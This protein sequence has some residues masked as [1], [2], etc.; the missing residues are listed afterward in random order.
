MADRNAESTTP[1]GDSPVAQPAAQPLGGRFGFGRNTLKNR[2]AVYFAILLIGVQGV[3]LVVVDTAISGN[4]R[5]KI[6]E[7]LAV[8]ARVFRRQLE[9]NNNQ[10]GQAAEIL[11][12]DFAFRDAVGS[13][14]VP[15]I[16]SALQN[17][18][19]RI[20]ATVM[21]LA[22]PERRLIADAQ[23]PDA[24]GQPFA[25]P[26][27]IDAAERNGRASGL[28]LI[29][30]RAY[31]LVVVPVLAPA[32]I[33]WAAFGFPVDNR[34]ARDLQS[35]TELH[36]SFLSRGRSGDWSV[37]ASTIPAALQAP[38][39]E[40]V[41]AQPDPRAAPGGSSIG[42]IRLAVGEYESLMLALAHSDD[43]AI[44]AVL[45][46]S[47][48]EALAPVRR[49]ETLLALLAAGALSISLT[50]SVLIA[51]G[52]T[53]PIQALTEGTRRLEEGDYTRAVTVT[54]RD[55]IGELARRFNLMRDGI[56]AREDQI[57]R[58]AY[59]DV[60]TDLPNRALFN[61]RLNISLEVARRGK[62]PLTVLLMDLDRFKFINDTL[63]HQAGDQ[64]LR[65]L[66]QRLAG[67]V[68]KSDTTARLGGDEFALLLTG[69]DIAEAIQVAQKILSAL[70]EPVNV[71]G[72]AL[73]VRGSVGIAGFPVH[74]ENAE[75]LLRQADTAMYAAK[76]ASTGF[77]VYDPRQGEQGGAHLSL[78]GE[79]R[80]AVNRNE[81]T[82]MYQPKIEIAT[83]RVD[84]V[85]C[86]VRWVHPERGLIP[87]MHF[88]PFAEQTGFIR[89]ITE[90]VI[91]NAVAQC[92]K[93][94]A[95]G[96]SLKVAVN[97][98]AHD[99]LNP[100]LPDRIQAA[101]ARHKV[102]VSLL[103]ME[104]TES[105]IMQDAVHAIE[106]LGSLNALGI[107]LSIDDF[108]TG[109][110]SL[111]YLKQLPVHELKID[112]AFIRNIVSD[113]KDRAIVLS[114][115]E[116]GH[117][118]EL[119]VVAEGVEDE[120]S[121]AHLAKLDCDYAQGF[122]IARPQDAQ[123]FMHWH[124]ARNRVQKPADARSRA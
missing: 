47:L 108:G 120:A 65:Q 53:R 55:E 12:R 118:L 114:T 27:L 68:R 63:G 73:D 49:L 43:S 123:A 22:A 64:V 30:G 17:H 50:L 124:A 84:G 13:N 1:S 5:D 51:R 48:E 76:R 19:T 58:L 89:N 91:E 16:V 66:A 77:A 92:G 122:L 18:G 2:I 96:T 4:A 87:P 33:A 99:L 111:A 28:V 115:I 121:L 104:I 35:L 7:E 34:I 97:I 116:L 25:F 59:R 62:S 8:G 94:L 86:L 98:S 93:W 11:S 21:M 41:S 29:D 40:A 26:W 23:R 38:L 42:G 85:E 113:K 78:L 14:D 88:I 101:L 56:A 67:L 117:N 82:L 45:Q 52:I 32:P 9:Q 112:R 100:A 3:V 37:L 20:G 24:T 107:T 79:L 15:T 90:W 44:V 39:R 31:Q 6:E 83:G 61:D 102:P 72:Q 46:R 103:S 95:Q 106:L 110:S 105:A 70:E 75:T 36:V 71:G 69:T 109:Y 74:G 10:L 60:L 81:L 54:S 119:S 80:Q 57:A